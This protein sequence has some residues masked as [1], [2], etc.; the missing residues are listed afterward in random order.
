MY[1]ALERG[2]PSFP[3]GY[4]CPAV[5]TD[6]DQEGGDTSSTGLSPSTATPSRGLPLTTTLSHSPTPRQRRQN[7]PTT[8]TTQRLPAL[9]RDRF[10]LIRFRSPLLTE[11]QLFSLPAGTEMFHFPAF[12]P[13]A[14]CVQAWVAEFS[15][16]GFPHSDIL[17]S[18]LG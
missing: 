13:H 15:S 16:T 10:S 2:R 3:R 5:L 11:S 17:G 4:S 7:G 18:Q 14:L 6:P 12:P 1:L 9:T 8:P